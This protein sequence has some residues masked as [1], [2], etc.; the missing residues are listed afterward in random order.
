MEESCAVQDSFRSHIS[1]SFGTITELLEC[2]VH[3]FW[4]Q[5]LAVKANMSSHRVG[6]LEGKWSLALLTQDRS[7]CANP[8]AFSTE[9]HDRNIRCP[10]LPRDGKRAA[11]NS[12]VYNKGYGIQ[13]RTQCTSLPR[14]TEMQTGHG[15][16]F[17]A[18][19]L[20]E[21]DVTAV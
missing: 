3:W 5:M 13:G 20:S 16:G 15:T 7:F 2:P 17:S 14:P 11:D 6:H 12:L 21:A 18:L 10:S 8:F 1:K 4:L 9:K 19:F